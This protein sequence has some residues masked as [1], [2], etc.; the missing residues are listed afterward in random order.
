MVGNQQALLQLAG[1][2]VG[3]H[4]IALLQGGPQGGLGHAVEVQVVLADE[5]VNLGVG[6]APEVTH[7]CEAS[8][9]LLKGGGGETD[10][11][12]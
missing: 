3:A 10:G 4:G 7:V 12:P 11:S 6:A 9:P 1:L 2:G 5:L 8:T